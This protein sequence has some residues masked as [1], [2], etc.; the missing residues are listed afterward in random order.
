VPSAALCHLG[1]VTQVG[2]SEVADGRCSG[3]PRAPQALAWEAA[4]PW[5]GPSV[6]GCSEVHS[7]NSIGRTPE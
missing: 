6:H 5:G 1:L 2:R 7:K 3:Q 4:S